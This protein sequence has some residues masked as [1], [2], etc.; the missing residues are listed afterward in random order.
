MLVVIEPG[1]QTGSGLVQ[2]ARSQ[3]L[4]LEARR[5]AREGRRQHQ[6][7]QGGEG[8]G[9]GGGLQQGQQPP[10]GAHVLAPCPHDGFCPLMVGGW[11]LSSKQCNAVHDSAVRHR[12]S[13]DQLL[14]PD[15]ALSISVWPCP[16]LLTCICSSVAQAFKL[17]G[18]CCC[19]V[20]F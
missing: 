10:V 13:I 19:S 17:T 12:V 15:F 2:A 9:G 4:G 11:V 16:A 18:C 5:A 6:H 8:G 14:H 7:D 3:V 1:T 20:G